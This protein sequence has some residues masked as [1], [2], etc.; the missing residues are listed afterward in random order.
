MLLVIILV[1]LYILYI[2]YIFYNEELEPIPENCFNRKN[3]R[4][5]D[6]CAWK[7]GF[8]DC[9]YFESEYYLNKCSDQHAIN[10]SQRSKSKNKKRRILKQQQKDEILPIE[11]LN[12]SHCLHSIRDQT[13]MTSLHHNL[14][15]KTIFLSFVSC[16]WFLY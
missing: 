12:Y 10:V 11:Q 15:I 2:L 5:R 4:L 7:A 1:I 9:N 13:N 14:H 8:R 3:K 16:P 6:Q